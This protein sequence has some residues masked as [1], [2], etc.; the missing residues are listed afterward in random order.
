MKIEKYKFK[1]ELHTHSKPVSECSEIVPE[2]IIEL[3]KQ[4][5]ADAIVLTNHFAPSHFEK[6][7]K[8]EVIDFWLGD[9]YALKTI[10]EK[11]GITV[12]LGMEIRFTENHNDYLVYGIDEDDV[13]IAAEFIDKGIDTFYKEFKNDRNVILQAHPFRDGMV[14]ANPKS[15]DGVEVFNIHPH[16]NSR[17][18]LASEY[19]KE[20]NFL[21]SGGS[22]FHH[23]GH[24][25]G[26]FM[27]TRK[28]P[29]DSF[30]IAKIIKEKDFLF[31]VKGNIII[32]YNYK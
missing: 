29:K 6:K 2:R 28:K 11:H 21:V 14:L 10:G 12:I 13:R 1:T 8:E 26:C 18:S 23:E 31:D 5:D 15:I 17:I 24:Q 7:P 27:R 30:D 4:K 22:D 16:H 32:P 9:Y 20:N 25:G 19:A 3:Y